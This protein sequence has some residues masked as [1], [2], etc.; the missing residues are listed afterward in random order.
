MRS[1][2]YLEENKEKV[3]LE[4]EEQKSKE[5]EEKTR[6]RKKKI[7]IAIIV[8]LLFILYAHVIDPTIFTVREY[9][10][11]SAI[12]PKS[13]DGLKIVHISDIH[14]GTTIDK[15]KLNK[16]V[17]MVNELK[18]DVVVFTGD[19]FDKDIVLNEDN[20]KEMT[21][22]L[23]K[24]EPRLYKY[25]ITGNEDGANEKYYE[26]IDNAGFTLL[27]NKAKVLFDNGLD[28]IVFFGF[29]SS[30]EEKPDYSILDN[31]EYKDYYK[32][33]LLHEP[34]A[35]TSLSNADLVLA[36]HTMGGIVSVGTPLF[37]PEGA[38]KYYKET[39][40]LKNTQLFISNGLGT[41]Q[42]G[43]RFLNHPTINLYRLYKK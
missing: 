4:K 1:D 28:P 14:Y 39:Y 24:I 12:L 35:V 22:A 27:D 10:V 40:T 18:P 32:I 19:L 36:G 9:K 13:F 25:A 17:T 42:Y 29:P 23:G 30:L 33:V 16:I 20:Y 41:N 26:I 11:E 21:K 34:D 2:R 31:E 43:I 8:L 5:Q 38:S 6:K 37:K 15:K 3:K 7:A